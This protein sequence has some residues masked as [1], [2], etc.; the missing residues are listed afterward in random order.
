MSFCNCNTGLS[1]LG[2]PG[3]QSLQSVTRRLIFVP[4][5]KSNGER[6][7]ITL[8]EA[9]TI[10]EAFLAAKLNAVLPADRWFASPL[11]DNVE[12]TKADSVFESLNSGANIFVQEG[13]RTFTG[14]F[15]K[16]SP[17]FLGKLKS[18]RCIKL[19]VY[20]VDIDGN[21]TGSINSDGTLL[22]PI[23]VDNE[24]LNPTLVK[25]TDTTV[26]KVQLSFEFSRNERDENL[27][28]IS[29]GDIDADLLSIRSM[30]DVN[31]AV[32]GD[33]VSA[34]TLQVTL[35]YGTFGKPIGVEGIVLADLSIVNNTSL[36]SNFIQ[37]VTEV[38][39]GIYTITY[40]TP[41]ALNDSITIT[42]T[43]EWYSTQSVTF[44]I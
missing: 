37:T 2:T 1:N 15:V 26:A 13:A 27:M 4:L 7:A 25:A 14:V 3:C 8:A 5:Y 28:S 16:Q 11:I 20:V 44:T 36:G 35:D 12:D 31:L 40:T 19:G 43:K 39:E 38:G 29:A 10:N 17:T 42:L 41:Q 6:A 9:A 24:T 30:L 32:S 34:C 23:A 33:T 18:G 22:Y 21:L